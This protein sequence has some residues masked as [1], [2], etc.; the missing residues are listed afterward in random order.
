MRFVLDTNEFVAALGVVKNTPSETLLNI[1]LE[2]FPQHTLHIPRIIIN[3]VK[4]NTHPRVF[5]EFIRIIQPIAT[6]DEDILVPF[7]IGIKYESLGLKSADAFIAAYTEWVGAE[8]LITENRH[9]LTRR[10]DL[11]FKF[12]TAESCLRSLGKS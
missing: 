8:A 10:V 5:A 3:E 1:L 9:F 7:E 11:P 6:I 2:S 12:L 4:R